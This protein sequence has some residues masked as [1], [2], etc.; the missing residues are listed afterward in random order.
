MSDFVDL[1]E[2]INVHRSLRDLLAQETEL[3]WP[4]D[5]RLGAISRDMLTWI[6]MYD[7]GSAASFSI[8]SPHLLPTYRMVYKLVEEVLRLFT[9]DLPD[10]RIAR[11]ERL[12]RI[13]N[14]KRMVGRQLI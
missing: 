11:M 8:Y 12:G 3:R 10:E 7:T 6:F 14:T 9:A 1:N 5:E 4:Y 2:Q 13:V